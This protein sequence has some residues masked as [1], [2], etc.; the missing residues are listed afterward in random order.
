[1][2]FLTNFS[3][4]IKHIKQKKHTKAQSHYFSA[5]Q[6]NERRQKPAICMLDLFS[7]VIKCVSAI[8]LIKPHGMKTEDVWESR[9]IFPCI[10]KLGTTLRSVTVSG[11]GVFTSEKIDSRTN[12]IGL[13][14]IQTFT[15]HL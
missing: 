10:P 2:Q 14:R 5:Q 15:N 3:N 12:S 13:F 8:K 11:P 6:V 4:L 1:L 9:R 7:L